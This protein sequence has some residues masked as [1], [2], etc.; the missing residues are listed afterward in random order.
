MT[1]L[2]SDVLVIGSSLGGL[3]AAT[4]LARAGLR[5]VLVEEDTLA[6]R[7]PL[8]REPFVLSGLEIDGPAHRVF[9]E[10]A[11]PLI[12]QRRIAQRSV[13]LQVLLP[14]ARLDVHAGRRDLARELEAFDVCDPGAA[15]SFFEAADARGDEIRARLVDGDP[16]DAGSP[17]VRRLLTSAARNGNA[18]SS[19]GAL[20]DGLAPVVSALVAALSR[21][22]P[23]SAPGR[24]AALLVRATR[25]GGFFMPDAGA[26]FLD[27]FRRRF[28]TL[29]GEIRS[30]GDFALVSERGELGI[31]L[32]RGR[33]FARG[34]MLAAPLE[35]LRRVSTA[36]GSAPRW[37]GPRTP[38]VDVPL[39]LFRAEPDSLPVGLAARAVVVPGS[40]E[41]MHWVARYADPVQEGV[42]W[43]LVAGPG[44][45][46]LPPGQPL[47]ALNPFPDDGLVPIDLGPAPRWDRDAADHRFL[48][49]RSESIVRTKPS[50]FAVG[51]EIAP[52]LGF[53]GELLLARQAALR[54]AER[55]G[56]KRGLP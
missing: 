23:E 36:A 55:L 2:R 25:E 4:Y 52:G 38:P 30:A 26:P 48:A 12:E 7:P 3:V 19:L 47:G 20:P 54:L 9:R 32:P 31:E 6:K 49:P 18:E 1:T 16:G 45:E 43:L 8:L 29:H 5:V 28:L 50:V 11:L 40:P 35:L 51:A 53:E 22:A 39:R 37:L 15:Q 46:A 24:D 44:A 27:L 56:A 14:H 13:S 41:A 21:L 42:E 34:V 33:L 17:L 10:L